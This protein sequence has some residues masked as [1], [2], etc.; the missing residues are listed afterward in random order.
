MHTGKRYEE[1]IGRGITNESMKKRLV[2]MTIL[3]VF[4]MTLM[5]TNANIEQ[6]IIDAGNEP[7]IIVAVETEEHYTRVEHETF[8]DEQ[9]EIRNEILY[10]ELEQVAILVQA[11][12]GNQDEL[13]QRY[14]ADVVFNR[15]DDPDFPDNTND[16]IY[17]VNPVQFSTTVDG[18]MGKAGYEVK[19]ETFQLVLEEYNKRTNSEIIY[20]RTGNYSTSGH[21]AFK[22]GD[23]YFST[24]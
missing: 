18:A 8:E 12:A 9:E 19:E 7:G 21:P 4:S 17:Q 10:G 14:V 22:H 5:I 1:R 13:G 20:F 24:K 15:V 23:H 16:V 2:E 6:A 11:E 3:A